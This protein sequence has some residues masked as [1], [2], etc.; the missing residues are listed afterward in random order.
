MV[1][2]GLVSLLCLGSASGFM[3]P[4]VG[5]MHSARNTGYALIPVRIHEIA[6]SVVLEGDGGAFIPRPQQHSSTAVAVP[7]T[8]DAGAYFMSITGLL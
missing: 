6:L 8:S 3:S 1:T 5:K 4:F 2:R 7:L